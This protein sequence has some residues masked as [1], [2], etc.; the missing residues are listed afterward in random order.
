MKLLILALIV[1]LLSCTLD[2]ERGV[3]TSVERVNTSVDC[4]DCTFVVKGYPAKGFRSKCD[5]YAVGDSV[6]KYFPKGGN[7]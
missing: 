6:N 7:Q 4:D 1:M 3:I 2:M 5:R